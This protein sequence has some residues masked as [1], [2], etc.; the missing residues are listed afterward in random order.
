MLHKLYYNVLILLLL[1]L[2]VHCQYDEKIAKN[3]F[4]P[5]AASAYS[6]KP[7]DCLQHVLKD[8]EVLAKY[9]TA[10]SPKKKD[11]C[12]GFIAVDHQ[13]K[14]MMI[15]FRGS[16]T[17]E[18][19][20]REI[21]DAVLVPNVKVFDDASVGYYFYHAFY[22]MWKSG[23]QKDFAKYRKTYDN[24]EI[25]ISGHSLGAA[26]ATICAVQISRI[27]PTLAPNISLYTFGEPRVGD[28]SFATYIENTIPNVYRVIHDK[29]IVTNIPLILA[30]KFWH[31]TPA[32]FYKGDMDIGSK[33]VIC[34]K[35]DIE[36]TLRY[37]P[38]QDSID[39]H[40]NY[41]NM[42]LSDYGENGCRPV[43]TRSYVYGD[44]I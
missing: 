8:T 40:L 13:N 22:I 25:W 44:D 18:Q 4:F 6:D 21:V 7:E 43:D 38:L 39:D 34:K 20:I 12:A 26:M 14:A 9:F 36:C 33:F 3:V 10:C 32:V 24:Y 27:Y 1:C 42:R 16:T 23:M 5:L 19:V 30:D 37:G 11:L 35:N 15:S 29:D 31:H 17:T 2:E 41:Y 28:R